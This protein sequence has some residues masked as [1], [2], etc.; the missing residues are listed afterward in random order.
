[1]VRQKQTPSPTRARKERNHSE[2]VA[3]SE[4][5]RYQKSTDLLIKKKS[6]QRVVAEITR[7][8]CKEQELP[9]FKMKAVA[10]EALHESAE[11]FIVNLFTDAT[12]CTTHAKRVTLRPAD[13]QLAKKLRG[14]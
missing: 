1:M 8:I 5:R 6:F 4:I 11:A 9:A 7:D 12:L 3:I 10:V 13:L 2:L 14:G